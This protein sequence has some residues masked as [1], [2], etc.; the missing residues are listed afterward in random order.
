VSALPPLLLRW[1]LVGLAELVLTLVLASIAPVFI[2][3]AYPWLGFLI[4]L[5]ILIGWIFS[6]LSV[7][8]VLAE[9]ARVRRLVLRHF[10]EEN[11][12]SLFAFT[13]LTLPKVKRRIAEWQDLVEDEEFREIGL[14]PWEFIKANH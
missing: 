8:I 13:G 10:P 11:D 9:A 7:A 6:I 4:W 5:G 2:N 12:R 3:S 14:S 1:I